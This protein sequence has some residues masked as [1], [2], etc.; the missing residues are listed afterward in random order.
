MKGVIRTL[1][2]VLGIGAA[3]IAAGAVTADPTPTPDALTVLRKAEAV[4]RANPDPAYTVY[5]MHEIFIHHGRQFTYDYHVWYRSD[6][7]A[8]MQNVATDRSGHHEQH[9][10]YPFPFAPDINIL[11]YATPAPTTAP[12]V[13]VTPT[14]NASGSTSPP[15][16][17]VQAITASR[18]YTVTLVGLEDY[19]GHSVYHLAL[20]PLPNVDE[21][22]HPWKDLWVDAQT[23]EVWKAHARAAG[24]NGLLSGSIEG[25]AEFEPVGAFWLLAHASGSGEG[26]MGFVSDSG[27]YEYFFS[28]FDFPD[29]LPDWYFDPDL[30]RH[31]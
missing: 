21:R 4:A 20:Q 25:T 18:Y 27:Q 24:T 1:A 15:L 8:L 3:M 2:I 10:G 29:S 11:L 12:H 30:F 14:P 23:F 16:I 31:H 17:S 5:D 28:G 19:Q 9:F 13:V 7:H 6:G 26:R 22:S